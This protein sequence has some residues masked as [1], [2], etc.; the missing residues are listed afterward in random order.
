MEEVDDDPFRCQLCG[1]CGPTA[2]AW[3][4]MLTEL[5][6][7]QVKGL[8]RRPASDSHR[9]FACRPWM[10][11]LPP[12][13]FAMYQLSPDGSR[14]SRAPPP[15]PPHR[16]ASRR[17]KSLDALQRHF[18]QLHA[19]E[20]QKRLGSG[21]QKR[22]RKYL[23]SDKAERYRCGRGGRRAGRDRAAPNSGVRVCGEG[24][25]GRCGGAVVCSAARACGAWGRT[26]APPAHGLQ[27][28][29]APP[30]HPHIMGAAAAACWA[31]T[32]VRR[33]ACRASWAPVA[34]PSRRCSKPWASGRERCGG[35]APHA[36][37]LQAAQAGVRASRLEAGC[38]RDA[39]RPGR[40]R[41]LGMVMRRHAQARVTHG[42]AGPPTLC[43]ADFPCSP[44]GGTRQGRD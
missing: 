19:R 7:G 14:P 12:P 44:P 5:G 29:V 3:A 31:G 35:D 27:L 40:R 42:A 28:P 41:A 26:C 43:G 33:Q 9:R 24:G 38:S 36:R 6:C 32:P 16:G 8:H 22:T 2:W 30:A 1:R 15:P 20:H 21:S 37:A 17:C 39:L 34:A 13:L 18:T 10:R 4:R 11:K 25:T 23:E